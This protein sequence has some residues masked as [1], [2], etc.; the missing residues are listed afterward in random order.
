M[1][2]VR[3]DRWLQSEYFISFYIK[4]NVDLLLN[5]QPRSSEAPALP[6]PPPPTTTTT[7]TTII[8]IINNGVLRWSLLKFYTR[9]RPITLN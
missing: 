3:R 7:T 5:T 9:G 6:V 1:V 8:I 2:S 4:L